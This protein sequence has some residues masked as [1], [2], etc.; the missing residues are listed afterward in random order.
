MDLGNALGKA[1]SIQQPPAGMATYGFVVALL[2]SSVVSRDAPSV[3]SLLGLS[4]SGVPV[5]YL[6]NP[7]KNMR[8]EVAYRRDLNVGAIPEQGSSFPRPDRVM[9]F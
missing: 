1:A 4:E 7:G 3:V 5:Q 2:F 6:N 9:Q 8:G